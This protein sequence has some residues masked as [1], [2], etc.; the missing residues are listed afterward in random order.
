M[1]HFS[2]KDQGG[3]GGKAE[4]RATKELAAESNSEYD[5][6]SLQAKALEC[7]RERMRGEERGEI[8]GEM[9]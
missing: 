4:L 6:I 1:E 9:E 7:L 8:E 5:R 3:E 2:L